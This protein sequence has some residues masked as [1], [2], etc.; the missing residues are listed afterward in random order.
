VKCCEA[1]YAIDAGV[2]PFVT[3]FAT[4]NPN[5][6]G[7]NCRYFKVIIRCP[8]VNFVITNLKTCPCECSAAIACYTERPCL[9]AIA[10]Y[11]AMTIGGTGGKL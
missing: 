6:G 8:I 11:L 2:A 4:K 7:G 9:F 10:S 1:F 5:R 3:I